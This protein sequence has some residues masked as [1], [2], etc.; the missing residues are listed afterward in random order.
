MRDEDDFIAVM[1]DSSD[2]VAANAPPPWRILVIDDDQEVHVATDFAL[3]G[4]LVAERP[5]ALVH[6]MSAAAARATLENDRDFAVVLLDVVME[7]DDAGLK[8]VHHLREVLGMA[9][10][11]IILRTGQPGYAPELQVFH[12]YDINDYRTKA[13]LT[14]TR[15]ITAISAAIR[16]YHQIHTIAENKHGLELLMRASAELIE[17]RASDRFANHVLDNIADLLAQPVDG[18]FCARQGGRFG[19]MTG[20]EFSIIGASGNLAQWL[21]CPLTGLGDSEISAALQQCLNSGEHLYQAQHCVISVC[22]G[23]HQGAIFLRTA[24]PINA[25][26]QQLLEVFATNIAACLGS[27]QLFE[28]LDFFAFHDELTH[29]RNRNRFILDLNEV[30]RRA[31]DIVVALIDL[32]HFADL[33]DGLGHETGNALLVAVSRRLRENMGRDCLLARIGADVFGI[34]GPESQL[35]P[36]HLFELFATPFHV[37]EHLLPANIMIGLC[38]TLEDKPSGITLLKRA[39]IALNR[40]KNDAAASHA[41]FMPEMEDST[42]W[43]LEIIHRLREDFAADRLSV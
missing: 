14:R 8:M 6:A 5:L 16:S 33:N 23:D 35:N 15:L 34:I 41:Y 3:Q 11:R 9:Q 10:T 36:S 32:Q 1:E 7:T 42:R 24:Q 40:A 21:S 22:A 2:D 30:G 25:A 13:E 28:Q 29:L 19:Q 12:D 43:R 39:N 18:I 20:R 4:V 27:V 37:G 31:A 26:Q 38:R 17:L